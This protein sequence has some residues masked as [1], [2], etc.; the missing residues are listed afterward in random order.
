[1]LLNYDGQAEGVD[2]SQI[3]G[4]LTENVGVETQVG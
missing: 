1:V 3:V 2:V 4:E